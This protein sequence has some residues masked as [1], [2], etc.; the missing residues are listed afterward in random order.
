MKNKWTN[1][2]QILPLSNNMYLGLI[3]DSK[4]SCRRS[5]QVKELNVYIYLRFEKLNRL[6]TSSFFFNEPLEVVTANF[7]SAFKEDFKIGHPCFDTVILGFLYK[8]GRIRP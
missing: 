8:L 5:L 2:T 4:S 1:D 7:S 3:G 6:N